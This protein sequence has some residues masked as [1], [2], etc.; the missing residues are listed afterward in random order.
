M[1]ELTQKERQL[2]RTHYALGLD[3][4]LGPIKQIIKHRKRFEAGEADVFAALESIVELW[5]PESDWRAIKAEVV[6]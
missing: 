1:T 6:E 5:E 4:V 3:D 2:A